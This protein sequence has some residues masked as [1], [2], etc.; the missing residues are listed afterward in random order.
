[1]FKKLL[2]LSLIIIAVVF[3]SVAQ[4]VDFSN[5]KLTIKQNEKNGK[6][7]SIPIFGKWITGNALPISSETIRYEYEN[8]ISFKNEIYFVFTDDLLFEINTEQNNIRIYVFENKT[9]Y[10]YMEKINCINDTIV[11]LRDVETR[12][13]IRNIQIY[14]YEL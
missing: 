13:F 9:E 2:V 10:N 7:L 4:D 14:T 6:S 1:M 5:G 12:F 3:S 8:L 11:S